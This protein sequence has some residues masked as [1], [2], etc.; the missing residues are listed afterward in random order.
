MFSFGVT[1]TNSQQ[2][3]VR[4]RPRSPSPLHRLA[5]CHRS[6][7]TLLSSF[8]RRSQLHISCPPTTFNYVGRLIS[9]SDIKPGVYYIRL[10]SPPPSPSMFYWG[11]FTKSIIR[12]MVLWSFLRRRRGAEGVSFSLSTLSLLLRV[13]TQ[14]SRSTVA[15]LQVN[16]PMT[17][18]GVIYYYCGGGGEERLKGDFQSSMSPDGSHNLEF[19]PRTLQLEQ[20]RFVG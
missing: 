11:L 13:T 16:F 15:F 5:A 4:P 2:S 1:T 19:T 6:L 18:K 3:V 10:N 9:L 7:S 20:A 12:L 14:L 17:T 8:P